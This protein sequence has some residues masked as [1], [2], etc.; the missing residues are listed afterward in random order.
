VVLEPA[1]AREAVRHTAVALG[2]GA[3]LVSG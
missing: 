1:A 3:Q 2:S